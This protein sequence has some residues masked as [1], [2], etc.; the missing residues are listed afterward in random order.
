MR[1]QEIGTKPQR[2]AFLANLAHE[3]QQL[4]RWEENLHYSA[5]RLLQVFPKYFTPASARAAAHNP[6]RIASI[7]YGGRMGN[8]E[9]GDGWAYRGRGPIGLTGRDNYRRFGDLLGVDLEGNPDL[10]ARHEYGF[11]IAALFWKLG[12][13]NELANK[14]KGKWPIS[15]SESKLLEVICRR[16]NGGLNGLDDRLHYYEL[17]C[18]VLH[19]D[20]VDSVDHTAENN[21]GHESDLVTAALGSEKAKSAGLKLWPRLAKHASAAASLG[22]ALVE[23]HKIASVLVALVLLAGVG[24]VIYHNRKP[25]KSKLLEVLK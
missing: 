13:C 20:S 6:E 9:P 12:G 22:V 8:H 25:L 1:E 23:A 24:W 3:S 19:D 21:E 2:A 10:A 17:A 14:L 4:T 5:G 15:K 7:V 16:I 18:Q 11:R